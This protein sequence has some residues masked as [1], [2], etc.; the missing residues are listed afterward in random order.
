VLF[1]V[2]QSQQDVEHGRGQGQERFGFFVMSHEERLSAP[3]H[4]ENGCLYREPEDYIVRRYSCTQVSG[5][6][7]PVSKFRRE[8]SFM[9][10]L[11]GVGR[12]PLSDSGTS[13]PA[14]G[15][16]FISELSIL[17]V[18]VSREGNETA[19]RDVQMKRNWAL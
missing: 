15:K 1:T 3:R 16:D 2:G 17:T 4:G 7:F 13:L 9:G 10:V 5:H 18:V 8:K 14:S 19:V 6:R 12:P 11:A